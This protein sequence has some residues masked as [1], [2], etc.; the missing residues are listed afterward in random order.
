MPARLHARPSNRVVVGL[1]FIES[2]Q[3]APKAPETL[4]TRVPRL[5]AWT[6]L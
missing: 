3:S 4:E 2:A 6:E 5:P 1:K